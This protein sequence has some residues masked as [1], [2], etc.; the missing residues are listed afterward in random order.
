MCAV[1][2]GL[3]RR[4]DPATSRFPGLSGK[5]RRDVRRAARAVGAERLEQKSF[6]REESE[7]R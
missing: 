4:L 7:K 5:A 6:D 3:Y 2:E 1:A